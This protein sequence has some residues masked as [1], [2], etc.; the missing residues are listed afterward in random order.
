MSEPAAESAPAVTPV[1]DSAALSRQA[2]RVAIQEAR[3][4]EAK[5][6]VAATRAVAEKVFAPAR[7]HGIRQAE[8]LLPGGVSAGLIAIKRGPSVTSVQPGRLM[9]VAAGNDAHDIEDYVRDIALHDPRVLALLAEYYPD[10]I[11]RRIRPEA[12]ALYAKEIEENNG[13]VLDRA[14]MLTDPG[15]RVRVADITHGDAT[16]E[17]SFRPAPKGLQLVREALEAGLL[18]EDGLFASEPEGSPEADAPFLVSVQS[19]NDESAELMCESCGHVFLLDAPLAVRPERGVAAS[20]WLARSFADHKCAVTEAA[21]ALAAEPQ[22]EATAS[23]PAAVAPASDDARERIDRALSRPHSRR[24]RRGPQHP[25]TGEQAAILDAVRTGDGVVISAGAGTG[26]TSSLVMIGE[27]EAGRSGLYVAFNATIVADAKPRFG[28]DVRV[29]TAHALAMAAVGK[30][31]RHR[32][33]AARVPALQVAKVL[34]INEPVRVAEDRILAPA[35]LARLVMETVDRFCRSADPVLSPVHVPRKA[36]LDTPDVMAVLRTALTPWAQKAWAD[37]IS[38]QGRLRYSHDTYLK[39]WGLT[40]PQLSADYIMYDECQDADAVVQAVIRDQRDTQVIAVGDKAQQ[41]YEW[42]GAVDAMDGFEAKYRLPLSKSFRFG[43]AIAGEAN[44]WL[45]ILD[46]D[47]RLTGFDQVPSVIR[48]LDIADAVLCRTNA[49]VIAQAMRSVEAGHATAIVG[50]GKDIRALAEAAIA[51][52]QGRGTSHPELYAF[53]SWGEVQDHAEHDP[54]G[55]DLRVLVTLIDSNGPERIIGIID[56]LTDEK[57]AEVVISTAHKSK[58][59]EWDSVRIASDFHPPKGS[60]GDPDGGVVSPPDA[61]LAYVAVT[62]AKL[63]L[64]RA[65]LAWVDRYALAGAA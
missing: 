44:K 9:L 17:F 55:S 30:N 32:L 63:A 39:Q 23:E 34:G 2:L 52:K 47:L 48:P 60:D 26:K 65:G 31:Y 7:Q 58:G 20:T 8:V 50:G 4:Q 42:R 5:G 10:L 33:N 14:G 61:R 49:E 53:Q 27:Q 15:E 59:R 64:D 18:T 28:P 16:G 29:S 19:R 51:L 6:N 1:P 46:A 41:L 11:G 12:M 62:R 37:L 57:R 25:P 3:A 45:D 36:G 21:K 35:Q 24:A 43:P 40:H 22:P 56:S 38:I 13:A 54:S